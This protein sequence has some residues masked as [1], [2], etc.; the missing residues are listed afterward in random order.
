MG[1]APRGSGRE[2]MREMSYD[3]WKTTPPEEEREPGCI[4]STSPGDVL[5]CPNHG[6]PD[7][8][9][10]ECD[11]CGEYNPLDGGTCLLCFGTGEV[12]E[13]RR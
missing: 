5:L 3:D 6:D 8:Q 12:P 1:V 13:D 2:G 9:G 10:W 4:C 11:K 7:R